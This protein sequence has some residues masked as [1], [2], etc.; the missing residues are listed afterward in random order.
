M[1]PQEALVGWWLVWVIHTYSIQAKML[2]IFPPFFLKTEV[3]ATWKSVFRIKFLYKPIH[4][5]ERALA[6]KCN[7]CLWWEGKRVSIA[8][9]NTKWCHL[10]HDLV[11]NLSSSIRLHKEVHR[12][13][14]APKEEVSNLVLSVWIWYFML[15]L[16][17]PFV[18]CPVQTSSRWA[19]HCYLDSK[20]YLLNPY[21]SQGKS[22][23]NLFGA[24]G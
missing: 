11:I 13:L 20:Q 16:C 3:D 14:R 19:C 12:N 6:K 9:P 23:E 15:Q 17:L 7:N 5:R 2:Q 8:N 24:K 4:T 1:K 21:N 10:G 22:Q 18:V